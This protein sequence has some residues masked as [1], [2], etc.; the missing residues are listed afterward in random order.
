[1]TLAS[2]DADTL[3]LVGEKGAHVALLMALVCKEW[4]AAIE[5]GQGTAFEIRNSLVSIGK[6]CVQGDLVDAL[7]LSP[8]TI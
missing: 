1:M 2:M 5:A 6:T 3:R 8:K 7:S 4:R